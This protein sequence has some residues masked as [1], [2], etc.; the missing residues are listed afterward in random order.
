MGRRLRSR[1]RAPTR[2]GRAHIACR[3]WRSARSARTQLTVRADGRAERSGELADLGSF[4]AW[5]PP[6][7]GRAGGPDRIWLPADSNPRGKSSVLRREFPNGI[8]PVNENHGAIDDA[9]RD[10]IAPAPRVEW[11]AMARAW[12]LLGLLAASFG[13]SLALA[14]G[15]TESPRGS[16]HPG[17]AGARAKEIL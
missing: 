9:T 5:Q 3:R 4:D 6:R 12:R 16:G 15:C 13:C 14:L 7:R 11:P 2:P 10:L 17:D 8:Q 1:R